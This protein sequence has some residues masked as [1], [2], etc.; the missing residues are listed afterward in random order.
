MH[1]IQLEILF[2]YLY[3][4]NDLLYPKQAYSAITGGMYLC[5]F[6]SRREAL[7]PSFPSFRFL[8]FTLTCF[9]NIK[10]RDFLSS[11]FITTMLFACKYH[12]TNITSTGVSKKN[13]LIKDE[14]LNTECS[15]ESWAIKF[16]RQRWCILSR[17][18]PSF[19]LIFRSSPP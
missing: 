4:W 3:N 1:K 19:V 8:Y 12:L 16:C 15:G 7:S 9:D 10:K 17:W 5:F 18:E 14:E 13:V 11:L 2:E 6:P